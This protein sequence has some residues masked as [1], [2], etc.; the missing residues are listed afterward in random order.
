MEL[1]KR[2]TRTFVWTTSG[3]TYGGLEGRGVYRGEAN[4]SCCMN[5]G[6][7][8]TRAASHTTWQ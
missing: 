5:H 1:V 6:K 8:G 7:A 3:R 2:D 4:V